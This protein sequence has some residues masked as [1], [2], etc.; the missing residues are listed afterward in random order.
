[1]L[2]EAFALAMEDRQDDHAARALVNLATATLTR[3][4][5]DPHIPGHVERALSFV[6]ERELEGYT[7]YLLGVRAQL[8]LLRGAWEQAEVDARASLAFGESRG[9]SLC[10]ALIVVGRLQARR[11]DGRG[12]A[13]ARR[14]VAPRGRDGRAAAARPGRRRPR[15]G[16]VA[17]G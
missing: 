14:R 12:R 1:M 9:V 13:D 10:P 4:R 15:R 2:E 6:R 16:R 7:Q 3:R 11:G 17:G 8:G 5:G